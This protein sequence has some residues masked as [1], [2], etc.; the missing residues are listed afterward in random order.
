M[1]INFGTNYTLRPFSRQA[2]GPLSLSLIQTDWISNAVSLSSDDY[3][4]LPQFK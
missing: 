4:L 2:A 3:L 1:Q